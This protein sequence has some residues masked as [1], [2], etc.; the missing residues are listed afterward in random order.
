MDISDEFEFKPLTEGLGFHK[1]QVSLKEE[2]K[3]AEDHMLRTSKVLPDGDDLK[4][5]NKPEAVSR[6]KD[7][8]KDFPVIDQLDFIE[9][10]TEKKK[11][12]LEQ[13][14]PRNDLS[15]KGMSPEEVLAK[16]EPELKVNPE[17]FDR[18][19][20]IVSEIKPLIERTK[21]KIKIEKRLVV[22]LQNKRPSLYTYLIDTLT[23]VGLT[24]V[25]LAALLVVT[26]V[27]VIY[28]MSH[29]DTDI[30]TKASVG[31]LFLAVWLFYLLVSRVFFGK[32]LG[33]WAMDYQLGDVQDQYKMSYP[34]KITWR[35]VMNLLTGIIVLPLLSMI[36][37]RDLIG[38]LSFSCLY[39]K[40]QRWE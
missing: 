28:I 18:K 22:E 3:K 13:P 38:S 29:P 25:F 19:V 36:F 24:N 10:T 23:V 15:T 11:S 32:T 39:K 16:S 27:D 7:L 14:L 21:E 17:V 40:D 26:K 31:G 34:F 35:F 5:L 12:L 8:V 2:N 33:E 6:V 4:G 37:N 20:G 1:K 9:D 30:L